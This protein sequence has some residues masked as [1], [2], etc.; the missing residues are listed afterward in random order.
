[1]FGLRLGTVCLSWPGF[2]DDAVDAAADV[3]SATLRTWRLLCLCE[4]VCVCA[5]VCPGVLLCAVGYCVEAVQTDAGRLS[6]PCGLDLVQRFLTLLLMNVPLCLMVI[7]MMMR[8]KR[9]VMT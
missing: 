2:N 1:M 4:C 6:I 8:P 3:D 9:G 7:M 5:S